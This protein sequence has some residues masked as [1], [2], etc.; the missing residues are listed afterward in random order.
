MPNHLRST[1]LQSGS[2]ASFAGAEAWRD[3]S[4]F[5]ADTRFADLGGTPK[6]GANV[7]Y[8]QGQDL[9]RRGR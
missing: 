1:A 5:V 7:Q 6:G 9:H 4:R 3:L 8:D 2:F